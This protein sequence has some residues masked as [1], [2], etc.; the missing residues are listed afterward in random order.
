[1]S[2]LVYGF[3][4]RLVALGCG[5]AVGSG[6][7]L[8]WVELYVQTIRVDARD[9]REGIEIPYFNHHVSREQADEWEKAQEKEK[10]PQFEEVFAPGESPSPS[11][12]PRDASEWQGMLVNMAFQ[13]LCDVSERC[14]LAMACHE[15]KCGP[16]SLDDDCGTGENCVLQHCLLASQVT[17]RS[18]R[19]CPL[20]EVCMLSGISEDVR[21]NR[22]MRSFCSGSAQVVERDAEEEQVAREREREAA[23]PDLRTGAELG[24]SNVLANELRQALADE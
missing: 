10:G 1:M 3:A 20:E 5:A 17:C 4:R 22:E 21:G 18:Q 7:Y 14:G 6:A 2:T 8:F 19:E 23:E 12:A 13:A 15:G 11:F 9:K 16:C 24:E